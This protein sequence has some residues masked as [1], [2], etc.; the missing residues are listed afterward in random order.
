LII[1]IDYE[2][3]ERKSPNPDIHKALFVG[4]GIL[5]EYIATRYDIEFSR[6]LGSDSSID[7]IIT[8]IQWLVENAM[9]ESCL[10]LHLAD[11]NFPVDKKEK[12]VDELSSS[13]SALPAGCCMFIIA[14]SPSFDELI[15]L[16][17]V[18]RHD[19]SG[20]ISLQGNPDDQ[21]KSGLVFALTLSAPKTTVESGLFSNVLVQAM[22]TLENGTIAQILEFSYDKLGRNVIPQ[23]KT[24]H[25][26]NPADLLFRFS[27]M[28]IPGLHDT[29]SNPKNQVDFSKVL[30]VGRNP[31]I[32]G[33]FEELCQYVSSTYVIKDVQD[34]DKSALDGLQ[35]LIKDAA[36]ASS[37]LF[38]CQTVDN[39]SNYH[40]ELAECGSKL[41]KESICIGVFDGPNSNVE[42]SYNYT[43]NRHGDI[44][45]SMTLQDLK[46]AQ[47][48][49]V[50]Q[51]NEGLLIAL[52][53]DGLSNAI[54]NLF[55]DRESGTV[56][57]L[58]SFLHNHATNVILASSRLFDP[59]DILF[60]LK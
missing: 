13:F 60:S 20:I 31:E 44:K 8:S 52:C 29:L 33:G 10:F 23:F 21:V 12:F 43:I 26:L 42:L 2:K 39:L 19:S 4:E 41:P 49:D 48:F 30:F 34:W 16:P 46:P 38:L 45:V 14:D 24:L 18:Y 9:E 6:T 22:E 32:S 36:I 55:Q 28:A 58:L 3:N 35:F 27:N 54:L 17:Y 11:L 37:M 50:D 51:G 57:D 5:D 59:E 15:D 7:S 40:Q 56:G 1:D 25:D 47:V 53:G